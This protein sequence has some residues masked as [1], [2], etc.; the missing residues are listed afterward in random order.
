MRMHIT[1]T[2]KGFSKSGNPG[3]S[4]PL[5][6]PGS[7]FIRGRSRSSGHFLLRDINNRKLIDA[8]EMANPLP[9]SFYRYD[10]KPDR[11]VDFSKMIFSSAQTPQ[12][13]EL[14]LGNQTSLGRLNLLLSSRICPTIYHHRSHRNPQD[15]TFQNRCPLLVVTC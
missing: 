1:K 13:R 3:D 14:A 4:K 11:E 7:S 8:R 15:Q 5:N 9:N 12:P 2:L 6:K 10:I